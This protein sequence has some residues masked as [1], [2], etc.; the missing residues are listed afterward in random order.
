[1]SSI[2]EGAKTATAEAADVNSAVKAAAE[3]LGI[4]PRATLYTLD[5][6]HFRSAAGGS[7]ARRTVKIIA[8][9]N[10]EG[11]VAEEA[12]APR[13][14]RDDDDRGE[15]RE[16]RERKPRRDDDRGERRERKPRRD[17]DRGERRE[18]KPRRDENFEGEETKASGVAAEWFNGLLPL[19]GLEGE[20]TALGNDER[21]VLTVKVDKAGR[22]IGRRGATLSA[23]RHLLKLTL[24]D[25]GDYI[26]DVDIPDDRKREDR[27]ERDDRGDRDDRRS[28]G[29]GRGRDRDRGGKG[30][31]PEEKLQAVA[32]RAA[33]KAIET[34]KPVTINLVLNSYDRHV[35]HAAVAEIEGADSESIVKDDKKYIQIS[36]VDAD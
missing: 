18:R 8:W 28:R 32:Q 22:L 3:E 2:P 34:G 27:R 14:S 21:V 29:R 6:D 24:S 30:D 12:P 1:M 19:M 9:E 16:R 23:V 20:V 4:S 31:Y 15:R 26:I 13:K 5:M 17:D 10:P 25:I 11:E 7:L 36:A 33:E 35:V